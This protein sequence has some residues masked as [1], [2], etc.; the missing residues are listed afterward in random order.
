M[1]WLFFGGSIGNV[2]GIFVSDMGDWFWFFSFFIGVNGG[3]IGWEE[4]GVEL[5]FF[6]L[7]F[8]EDSDRL[9]GI[10]GLSVGFFCFRR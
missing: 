10:I 6:G 1:V 2:M 4:G 8:G 3:V 5:R 9:F 7:R